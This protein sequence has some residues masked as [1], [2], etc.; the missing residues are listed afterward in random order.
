MKNQFDVIKKEVSRILKSKDL[1]GQ[2]GDEHSVYVDDT[3]RIV[4]G[5][6]FQKNFQVLL[7]H[8]KNKS[9][10]NQVDDS[11]VAVS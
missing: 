10:A 4:N 3:Y 5:V 11:S 9:S 7:C 2:T 1:A 8:F 6:S